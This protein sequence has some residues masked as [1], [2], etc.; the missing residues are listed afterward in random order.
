MAQK[1]DLLSAG[2]AACFAALEEKPIVVSAKRRVGLD[3]LVER[4]LATAAAP[5]AALSPRF[6]VSAHQEAQL[7]A[8]SELPISVSL[9]CLR[10]MA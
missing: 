8:A 9:R 10:V 3:G 6:L 4:V 5:G 1:S 7:L 2:E